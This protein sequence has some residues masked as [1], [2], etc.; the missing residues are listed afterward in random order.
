MRWL[1]SQLTFVLRK[2]NHLLEKSCLAPWIVR[3]LPTIAS[4]SRSVLS[5]VV[6][7]LLGWKKILFILAVLNWA[8]NQP[9]VTLPWEPLYFIATSYQS[10]LR[11]YSSSEPTHRASGFN[12][13]LVI[14]TYFCS[15][16][17]LSLGR[18]C[19]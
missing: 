8:G 18:H 19:S 5:C 1:L 3:A 14:G 17:L 6:S 4:C 9:K 7:I 12:E 15:A 11:G 13:M 2:H 10:I 16:I